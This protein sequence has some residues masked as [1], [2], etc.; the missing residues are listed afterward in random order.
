M[1]LK[2]IAIRKN[3]DVDWDYRTKSMGPNKMDA[4]PQWPVPIRFNNQ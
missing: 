2:E 4:T 1:I 3:E